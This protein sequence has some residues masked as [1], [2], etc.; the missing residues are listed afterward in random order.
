M[1]KQA[2]VSDLIT[3]RVNRET[4]YVVITMRRYP[5]FIRRELRDEYLSCLSPQS[6]LLEDF[7]TRKRAT[8]NH[9]AAFTKAGF[10]RRFMP[11]PEELKH[12]ERLARLSKKQDVVFVCQ[13]Q[14]GC[15]CH[16]E[17]NLLLAKELFGAKIGKVH[18]KY[19]EFQKRI[20]EIKKKLLSNPNKQTKL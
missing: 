9:N 11:D 18:H 8:H 1:L 7:L 5:R 10:E 17:M 3:D 12:L 2:S 20:K 19:P 4:A 13:C 6:K 16:R 14:V 15:R